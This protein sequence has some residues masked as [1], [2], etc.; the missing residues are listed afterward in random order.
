[1]SRPRR[2]ERREKET[3][4]KYK[5]EKRN[6]RKNQSETA[7]SLRKARKIAAKMLGYHDLRGAKRIVCDDGTVMYMPQNHMAED[8]TITVSA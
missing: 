6:S 4:M 7:T 2:R 5:I 8:V 3:E 1:M